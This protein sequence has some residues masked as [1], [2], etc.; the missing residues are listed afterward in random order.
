MSLPPKDYALLNVADRPF[1]TISCA[2]KNSD[3]AT[4]VVRIND[5]KGKIFMLKSLLV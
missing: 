2:K 1:Y 3:D 5:Q 4:V